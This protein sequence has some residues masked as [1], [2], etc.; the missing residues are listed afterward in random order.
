MSVEVETLL[1]L[2]EKKSPEIGTPLKDSFQ[3]YKEKV[4]VY[5][6]LM[7]LKQVEKKLSEWSVVYDE[8][9]NSTNFIKN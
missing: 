9:L 2:K 4:T 6:P 7:N 8:W 1:E 5:T 3:S